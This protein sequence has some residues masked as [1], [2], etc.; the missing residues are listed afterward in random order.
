[1]PKRA[2]VD[3]LLPEAREDVGDVGQ[4]GLVRPHEQHATPAL[5]EPRVGVQEVRGAVEG[6]DGLAGARTAVDH[7]RA[8]GAGSDDGVLVGLDRAEHVPHPGRPVAA[9][10]GDESGLVV[11]RGTPVEAVR[12]EHLVPVVA[13]PTAG[14]AIP[15]TTHQ[16]HRVRVGRAEER[17]GRRGAPVDQQSATRAVGEAESSDVHRLW[18]IGADDVS[19]AEVQAE[20]THEAQ[21]GRQPVDLLVTVQRLLAR[22]TGLPVERLLVPAW[23]LARRLEAVGQVGDRLLD[24]LRDGCEVLLVAG[25]QRRVGLGGE[26]V[27]E[28]ECAGQ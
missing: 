26:A 16:A 4:V 7:E 21:P 10:A 14:P 20:A 15:A 13:D 27:G 25:D 9:Q 18:I 2:G 3:A 19:E 22:A 28:G 1:M 5:L 6:D 12:G 8:A 23:S 11:E 24:A 17:L